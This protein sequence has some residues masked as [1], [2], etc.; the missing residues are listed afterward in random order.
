MIQLI[1]NE[2]IYI[3]KNIW[4][5][6]MPVYIGMLWTIVPITKYVCAI[7]HWTLCSP[8]EIFVQKQLSARFKNY[9]VHLDIFSMLQFVFA[10]SE[11]LSITRVDRVVK[12]IVTVG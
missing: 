9:V 8:G 10:V 3:S 12:S 1:Q 11:E 7:K 2:D 6:Y 5:Q 4:D